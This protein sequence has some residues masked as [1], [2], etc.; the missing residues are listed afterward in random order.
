MFKNL[1]MGPA[2]LT[3]VVRKAISKILLRE[4][5]GWEAKQM[6]LSRQ[7]E[8]NPCLVVVVEPLNF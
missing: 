5:A 6:M 2:K 8:K 3:E 4:N 1:I 7:L